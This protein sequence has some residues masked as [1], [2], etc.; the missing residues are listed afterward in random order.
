MSRAEKVAVEVSAPRSRCRERVI[1]YADGSSR[2]TSA[3]ALRLVGIRD[4]DTVSQEHL[5]TTLGPSELTAAWNRAMRLLSYRERSC[6]EL[7]GR[8]TEDGYPEL[9]I[10]HVLGRL[11][12]A[13]YLDDVRFADGYVQTKRTSG[14]GRRRIARGLAARGVA[15]D[16]AGHAL[17]AH[18]P[19]DDEIARARAVI[20]NLDTTTHPGAARA[21]R[22]LVSRG[23][24][25]D[26][27]RA[28]LMDEP[29]AGETEETPGSLSRQ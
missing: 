6:G 1:V 5:A 13:G 20:A 21:V 19:E 11:T 28:A 7:A 4:G 2:R 23:F 27:A 14:W 18:A 26:T 29:D 25:Y 16:L 10:G 17:D 15:P 22:R 3:D 8:L 24:A 12:E 9:V